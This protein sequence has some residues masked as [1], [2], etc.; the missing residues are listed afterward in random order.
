MVINDFDTDR[1]VLIVAE[2][3]N[4][5]EGSYALA[6]EL[7]GLAA[8]AGADAVKFQTFRTQHYVSPCDQQRFEQLK[9]FELRFEQFER[10]SKLARDEGVLFLSTPFDIQ[11]AQALNDIVAAYKISSGD[12][13]FYPLLEV[14]GETG[15]PVIVSTGLAD[16]REIAAAKATIERA[17]NERGLAGELALLH[18]V[19]SYPVPRDQANL[20]AIG[21]LKVLFGCTV[22][23]SDHT[24]GIEAA[25]LAVAAGARIVEKHFTM[26]NDYSAFRDHQL[27]ADPR[28][29]AELGRRIRAIET[30]MGNGE[31]V[32]QPCERDLITALRR[33]I[34]ANRDLPAG[35]VLSRDDLTWVRPG[36]GFVPGQEDS[37]VGRE[38]VGPIAAGQAISPDLLVQETAEV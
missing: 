30:L 15:K 9:S 38:L 5:H 1:R 31:K 18:C 11:S 22:G 7:I 25:A 12:I 16:L 36:G 29:M 17:R 28:E 24:L 37:V 27:S 14:V 10:L 6:E 8:Q 26:A 19:S 32:P 2:I 35:A 34:A 13:T 20:A 3:G 33:S 21:E 4:N 23:Y